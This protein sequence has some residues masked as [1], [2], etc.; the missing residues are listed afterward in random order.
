M[1]KS[2]LAMAVAISLSSYTS[3]SYAQTSTDNDT[4]TVVVTA[5]RFQQKATSVLA[6]TTTI[7]KQDI[8]ALPADNVLDILKALVGVEVVSSGGKAQATSI[9][10][11]G[12]SSKHSL[13]L[14]DGVRINS[15]TSGGSSIGLIPAFAIEQIEVIRG[16]RAAAY[17]SDAIGGV[18]SITTSA[19]F[20]SEHKAKLG[21]GSHDHS[22]VGIKSVGKIS[23][24]AKGEIIASQERS[25]G[26][27]V[28][29]LSSDHHG[30]EAQTLVGHLRNQ[31]ND[32]WLG[33]FSGY[34]K[35][36]YNESSSISSPYSKYRDDIDFKLLTGLL[37]YTQNN[38]SSEFQVS[39]KY[40]KDGY[41]LADDSDAKQILR[42]RKNSLSWL[43]TFSVK[44]ITHLQL[45]FEYSQDKA[46]RLGGYTT[47]Y[48]GTEKHI[49]SAYV[50]SSTEY[51]DFTY[52]LSAR[53]DDSS[54]FGHHS[55]WN[56]GL[57]YWFTDELQLFTSYGTGYKEPT[58]NDLY[59]PA[60]TFTAGNPDLQ[61]ESSTSREFGVRG[62]HSFLSWQMSVY[63][64]DIKNMI[65]WK[66]GSDS[67]WRPSNVENAV[68]T[69]IELSAS[70]D[71]WDINHKLTA[72]WKDPEDASDGAQLDKRAR[73]TYSW[74]M[75]YNLD[76]WSGSIV[77]NYVGQ[78][79]SSSEWLDSYIT[80][81]SA[82]KYQVNDHFSA[83]L[84]ANNLFDKGYQTGYGSGG[85]YRGEGRTVFVELTYQF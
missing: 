75:L 29:S 42:T 47:N 23:D 70:F 66:V 10:L 51:N 62:Y 60:S 44:D 4:D 69:G 74:T 41:G 30:Y 20:K 56:T 49:Q 19:E 22:F 43:N 2:A 3:F 76:K 77:T 1:E 58:F 26:Y 85:Y 35:N 53:Y 8:E 6:A 64:N 21:Y 83:G 37:R 48:G 84:K 34:M 16:P 78:R 39:T 33:Q 71:T 12:T 9:F 59:W 50:T 32:K 68:I 40:N 82:L 31:F 54:A 73:H 24:S 57:G 65:D 61:P 67:V 27:N 63:R 79:V 55:T 36:S 52:E 81:D 17:G 15:L 18:I 25:K 7:T 46:D 11:R 28:Y 80:L 72:D 5:N 14:L 13:V 45:G 38:L